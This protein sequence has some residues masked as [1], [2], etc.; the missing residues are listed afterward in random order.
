MSEIGNIIYEWTEGRIDFQGQALV[1]LI[2]RIVL[3]GSAVI[4]F[5]VGFIAQSLA[6]TLAIFGGSTVL[7]ALKLS[8]RKP[9]FLGSTIFNVSTSTIGPFASN[10]HVHVAL[11]QDEDNTLLPLVDEERISFYKNHP[12]QVGP[13][14]HRAAWSSG[15]RSPCL[16]SHESVEINQK[17]VDSV[18][19]HMIHALEWANPSISSILGNKKLFPVK[20]QKAYNVVHI[21][22]KDFVYLTVPP[23]TSEINDAATNNAS[24][25]S[26]E[27]ILK[28]GQHLA[29]IL[30]I[31]NF[32]TPVPQL[33]EALHRIGPSKHGSL[34]VFATRDIDIGDLIYAERPLLVKS[35]DMHL[36][37]RSDLYKP[38]GKLSIPQLIEKYG[39]ECEELESA[40]GLPV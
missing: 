20:K 8:N 14:I 2:S 18:L 4:A 29:A 30:S 26:S 38:G 34:G 21:P 37:L 32:P 5:I 40:S 24:P 33:S 9:R 13:G 7:L 17:A 15:I 12:S 27:C 10:Y 3:I 23:R 22:E 36:G 35:R 16:T 19:L 11:P 6:L 28:G 1:E 25:S 39:L 31:P